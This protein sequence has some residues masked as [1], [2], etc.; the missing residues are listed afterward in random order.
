MS[1]VNKIRAA[2]ENHLI[3]MVGAPTIY[4]NN[5]AYEAEP[6]TNFVKCRVVV[7]NIEPATRGLN[8]H[9]KHSGFFPTLICTPEGDGSGASMEIAEAILDRFTSTT[10]I[11]YDGIILT[12]DTAQMAN[13]YYSAPFDCLP[14][15]IN[16]YIYHS[17]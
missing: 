15:T 9:L 7:T 10:D 3:T 13:S 17:N 14:L 12:I 5:I 6:N 8:P 16:W 4:T 2:L 1:I 11:S